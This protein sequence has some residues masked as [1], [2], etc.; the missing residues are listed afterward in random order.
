MTSKELFERDLTRRAIQLEDVEETL[1][2]GETEDMSS[3][4]ERICETIQDLENARDKAVNAM[5]E[6]EVES[7]ESVKE[8]NQEEKQKINKFRD[9]RRQLK[10]KLASLA[11]KELQKR[12]QREQEQ[13]RLFMEEQAKRAREQ[14]METEAAKL[15]QP[16]LEE[17]WMQK[18]LQMERESMQQ[19]REDEARESQVV[20]LQK[21]TITPY[22]GDH[23]DWL[24]FWN[25]FSVEV[26]GSNIAE[27][28]KFN[29][30]LELVQENQRTTSLDFHIHQ[31]GTKRQRESCRLPMGRT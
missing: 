24:R 11:E 30:L 9:G 17:E 12:Q 13:Q 20:K 3:G 23:K 27:V 8:W 31:R 1:H 28:S 10:E 6:E 5:L 19:Y 7:L 4:Y 21:Y 26:E 16:K 18:K 14:L 15:K 22:R 2:S 25:Q 29:Y